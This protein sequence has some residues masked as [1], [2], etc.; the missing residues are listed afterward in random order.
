MKLR[1]KRIAK[2]SEYTI[3]NLY[4]DGEF[5]CN[6]LEDMDRGLKDSQS[7]LYIKAKKIFGKTAIPTGTY[8]VDMT[9][10]NRF[11]KVLPLLVGVKG[12]DG[13][14]IHQGNLPKDTEGCLLVGKNTFK[15]MVSDSKIT[16]DSLLNK[17]AKEKD[18][19]ITIE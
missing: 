12:F 9:Y 15:G 13:I 4:I 10:S 16:L 14:R 17:M 3:G 11:K 7:L 6:T 8:K 19:I 18:I 2:N 1:V 5:F